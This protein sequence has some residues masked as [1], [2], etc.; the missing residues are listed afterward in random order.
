MRKFLLLLLSLMVIQIPAFS[1]N[2]KM[3]PTSGGENA[4]PNIFI[5]TIPDDNV[6]ERPLNN[7]EIE[8]NNNYIEEKTTTSKNNEEEETVM[9]DMYEENDENIVLGATVLK[10]YAEYIE[11]RDT[12]YLKDDNDNF[13]INLKVPQKITASKG[14]DLASHTRTNQISKH[15]NTE[16]NIAPKSVI[17]SST[18]GDFTIGA[19]YENEV[20]NIAMLESETGLFTRYE[21]DKFAVS[22]SFKKSLNTTYA[23]DYNTISV[24]PELKLN[25]YI[26][27]KNKLSA[28][29]TRNR[30]STELIFSLNPFGKK[31]RDRM[32]LEAGAK[33]TFFMD[34]G[35]NKTQLNF[36]ATF[37]L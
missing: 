29:I 11:D 10:G 15:T 24:T 25:S 32:L 1:I 34:T 35:E 12:I 21:K 30:R 9:L 18:K 27:L 33:Q 7:S 26:S 31:D 5:Y 20:D 17:S 28:D 23:Q 4:L 22:S 37:K 8:E 2:K 36:S 19:L 3:L 14:L 16:Y 13:V 6:P